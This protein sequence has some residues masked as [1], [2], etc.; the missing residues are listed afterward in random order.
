MPY[1]WRVENDKAE[2]PFNVDAKNYLAINPVLRE[3]DPGTGVAP[4]DMPLPTWFHGGPPKGTL[5]GFRYP[6]DFDHWFGPL[7][8]QHLD[9]Y[10]YRGA[11][12][13]VEPINGDH[14][15]IMGNRKTAKPILNWKLGTGPAPDM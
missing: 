4:E 14:V 5:F 15:Q 10:G 7:V 9:K 1:I 3:P 6:S 2:G 13:E 12:Y 8:Q 11:I